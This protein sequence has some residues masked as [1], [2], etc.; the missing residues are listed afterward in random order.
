MSSRPQVNR[1]WILTVWWLA[2]GASPGETDIEL[3]A[4]ERCGGTPEAAK[5]T[6]D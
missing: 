1:W 5:G 3:V 4:A 6:V 2:A